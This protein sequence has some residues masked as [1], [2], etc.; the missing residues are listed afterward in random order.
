[1]KSILTSHISVKEWDLN[2]INEF[3]CDVYKFLSMFFKHKYLMLVL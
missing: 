1:M 3:Y 2:L